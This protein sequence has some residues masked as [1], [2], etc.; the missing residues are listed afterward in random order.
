M[1]PAS[2]S[3][4]GARAGNGV[5]LITTKQ[6]KKGKPEFSVKLNRGVQVPT[7]LPKMLNTQQYGE[8]LWNAM[9]NAGLQPAHS[10]YGSG[11]VPVIP[12]YILPAGASASQVDLSTYN[13]AGNQYM[14]ANKVGTDWAKEVY[15]PA[16]TTNLDLSA[17]G[18]GEDSKYFIGT[19]YVA[20]DAMLKWADYKRV[21]LRANSQFNAGKY[22]TFG[23]TMSAVYYRYT[24]GTSDGGAVLMA[25]IIPVRDVMGNWA[26]AKANGVGDIVN[27]VAGL[28]NQ[29]NN[30][31]EDI[32][33]LGNLFMEI[34]ILK[35]LKFKSTAGANLENGFT[36]SFSPTTY[37]NKGDKNVLVNSLNVGRGHNLD[38]VWNN[39]LTYSKTF[40]NN[41]S[42]N[43]LVG[44]E[45]VTST[46]NY[47][48]A[49]RSGFEVEDPD[50]WY[51]DAGETQKDNTENGS[52][53]SLFSLFSR[54]NYQYND[55]LYLSAIIRRDGSSRFG[56]GN[57]YGNFPGVSAAWRISK[58][59]FMSNQNI[60]SDLKL[61]A[62]YGVTGNQEIGNYAFASTYGT[63]IGDSSYPIDGQVNSVIQGI[64]KQTIGNANIKWESTRQT[65]IGIDAAFLKNKLT[66][67]LDYFNKYTS[68]IL[69][70]VPFP[71][72]AGR[73]TSPYENIGEMQNV[74]LEFSANY[75]NASKNND[76]SYDIGL[77]LFGFRNEVKK[78][79]QNQFIS[80]SN[81]RT[82]VGHPINSFYGY[83][84]DGIFQ[85]Q[86]QV[87]AHATQN[88]MALGRWMYRDVN[89]DG[90]IN[91]NDRTY[92]GNPHPKFEYSLNTRLK[93]KNF[94]MNLFV[95][96]TYG[97]K[98]YLGSKG[99]QTGT[100]FWGDYSNKSTRI[101]DTW[102]PSNP[103]AKLPQIN[104]LNPNDESNKVSTYFVENGSYLR[105]K[106]LE[107]GYTFPTNVLSKIGIK[108]SRVYINAENLLTITKYNGIDPE[109]SGDNG[110]DNISR[111]PLAKIFSLGFNLT[112]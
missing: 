19:N 46:R 76:F 37:W 24:G 86:A 25:P 109:V 74:G 87:D 108:Q 83:I 16:N 96:G 58:E 15:R 17:Q 26:G 92:I 28:Y 13:T 3:I 61:R 81:S 67:T 80:G 23:E 89:S 104:I 4:Y 111:M 18:G 78:L 70:I 75:S 82:D 52:A 2:A 88:G 47:L 6:G 51:L 60:F 93:Y 79:A 53:N 41:S 100:D 95:Q 72:S 36:K 10:Q 66:I 35:S 9:K 45:Y 62:S 56:P 34:N 38:A 55:K 68:G 20:Q 12:D 1:V 57:K 94:D 42:L 29:R 32:N 54:V 14:R 69:Q 33:V 99:G 5:I 101:L 110:N 73:A 98:I 90:V 64:S 50:Y 71:A 84:I 43:V 30:Y 105:V 103:N 22:V 40:S 49:S 59:S 106:L 31:N 39:T 97:N 65:N 11:A 91:D 48:G 7:N 77:N 112:F 44:T 63:D 8:V 85:N 21:S 107:F 102:T 27:P